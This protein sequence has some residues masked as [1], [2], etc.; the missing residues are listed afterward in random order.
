MTETPKATQV[1]ARITKRLCEIVG[2]TNATDMKHICYAYSYDLSFVKRKNPD[3]VVMPTSVEQVQEVMKFA[4]QEKIPVTPFTAGTN[5]GGLCIP[6]DGGILMD[7]K[8][9]NNIIRI[10]EE[11]HYAV[12]EPGVSHAKFASALYKFGLR[13]SWPVGPPSGSVSSNALCHGIGGLSGRYGLNS[14]EITSME[15]VLPTGELVRVGSC[16]IQDE[17]WQSCMPLPRVDGLFT[18]WL[19]TTGIITAYSEGF[20]HIH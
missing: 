12:I 14:E 9:M 1:D 3:Y 16:A 2:E 13:W 10:D 7:L 18:G 11:S 20:Y 4:N 6:E 17:S 15:V 5:I 8:R 19:G